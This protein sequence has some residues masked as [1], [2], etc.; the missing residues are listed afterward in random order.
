MKESPY[1]E[2]QGKIKNLP[3]FKPY[4][5]EKLKG[6]LRLSKIRQYEPQEL[7]IKEGAEENWMYF[8]ISGCVQIEKGDKIIS[9]LFRCGD[10][11]GEMG[12]LDEEPRSASVRAL[13]DTVCLAVDISH[14]LNV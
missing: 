5:E 10:I 1:L 14:L 12:F 11:F 6:L 7:I 13:K 2:G 4:S 8:M 9:A 3:V